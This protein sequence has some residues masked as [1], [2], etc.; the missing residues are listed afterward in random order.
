MRIGRILGL[1]AG[2]ALLVAGAGFFWVGRHLESFLN[3]VQPVALP[4]VSAQARALHFS[5]FVADMHADTLMLRGDLTVRSRTGHVDLPRLQAGGVALQV[6]TAVTKVPLGFNIEATD[7]DR[8]DLLTLVG[9]ANFSPFATRDL[10]GRALLYSERLNDSMARAGGMLLPVRSVAELDRLVARHAVDPNVVGALLGS[11]GAHP[12][13]GDPL[14]VDVLYGAGF[15][16]IGLAHFFDNEF[17]GS[18]HGL[19]KGG[20]TDKGREL[21]RRMEQLGMLVDLAHVSPAAIDDVL[22]MAGK[23]VVVSH[24]GVRGTCDNRRNLSDDQLRRIAATGGVVGIGYWDTAVCGTEMR[25]ITAAMRYAISVV[26]DDHIGLGSDFDGATT[27]GFDTSAL[28]ALTQQM[29]NDG[30]S[31]ATIR[32]ILGG[33]V[34]RVLRQVLPP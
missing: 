29:L 23:P 7:G 27:T 16:M 13:L 1:A 5:A 32:K 3:R 22:A 6:F 9:L 33:N 14:N 26:G 31:E 34:Q 17:S 30:M 2:I 12:L 24:G 8:L 4:G 11:E 28:P 15:R 10:L 25:Y 18:A 21:V 19:V 20:L